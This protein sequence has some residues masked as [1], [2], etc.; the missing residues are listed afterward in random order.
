MLSTF[1]RTLFAMPPVAY[2]DGHGLDG[3]F[4]GHQLDLH[5]LHHK[6]YV[7]KLNKLAKQ[8]NMQDASVEQVIFEAANPEANSS[9]AAFPQRKQLFNNA[10]QHFNHSFFWSCMTRNSRPMPPSLETRIT[11]EFGSIDCFKREWE[12]AAMQHFGSGWCWL[13]EHEGELKIVTTSNAD[14]PVATLDMFPVLC[15]DLWEHAFYVDYENRKIEYFK[16]WWDSVDWDQV[17]SNVIEAQAKASCT[18]C[19]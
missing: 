16:K 17:W 15:Q 13:V 8:V 7:N 4:S 14:T 1:T 18:V 9:L 3:V 10:A 2:M 19:V 12:T 11:E 5:A 6:A